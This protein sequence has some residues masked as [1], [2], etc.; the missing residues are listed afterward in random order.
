MRYIARM[1]IIAGLT[2][3]EVAEKLGVPIRT[4]QGWEMGN[5]GSMNLINAIKIADFY[6]VKDLRDL[7]K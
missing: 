3:R 4:F 5:M 7:L 1:R 6:G 2:Q